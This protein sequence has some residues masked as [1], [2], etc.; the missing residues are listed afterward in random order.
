MNSS[1]A[2]SEVK[3]SS[4]PKC[5]VCFSEIEPMLLNN[6]GNGYESYICESC[7]VEFNMPMKAASAE[8]YEAEYSEMEIRSSLYERR[9]NIWEFAESINSMPVKRGKLLEIGCGEGAFLEIARNRGYDPT[10]VDLNEHAVN[11]A[12]ISGFNA[13]CISAG[14]LLKKFPVK[15]FDIVCFFHV[16]EHLEDPHAFVANVNKLLKDEGYIVLSVPNPKRIGLIFG[17]ESWDYP[18]HH[19]T[20]W[21]KRSLEALL[22]LNNF[23]I[24]NL[25]DEPLNLLKVLPDC[26][27]GKI[28]FNVNHSVERMYSGSANSFAKSVLRFT[29]TTLSKCKKFFS[30][31]AAVLLLPWYSLRYRNRAGSSLLVIARKKNNG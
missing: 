4:S 23:E 31:A 6:P 15:G 5:P 25:K 18:P 20:S 21:N 29:Y 28:K 19:L 30:Q 8:W 26:L 22:Q 13:H 24:V 7:D 14:D 16:L 11:K 9:K 1:S 2:V 3:T 12:R 17:R 27:S 10:G